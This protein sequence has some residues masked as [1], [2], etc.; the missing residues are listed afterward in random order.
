MSVSSASQDV[1]PQTWPLGGG[2]GSVVLKSCCQLS[3]WE[4]QIRQIQYEVKE[5]AAR[6]EEFGQRCGA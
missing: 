1:G 5:L 6:V 2:T 4:A 3:V